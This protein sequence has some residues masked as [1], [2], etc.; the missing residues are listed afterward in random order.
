MIFENVKMVE[1]FVVNGKVEIE[2]WENDYVEVSYI[3]YGEVEVEV[4]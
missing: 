3:L 1:I 4:E 2:G